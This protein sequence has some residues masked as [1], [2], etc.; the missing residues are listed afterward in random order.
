MFGQKKTSTVK[1]VEANFLTNQAWV[2]HRTHSG[3]SAF[4]RGLPY[5]GQFAPK[6]V[7]LVSVYRILQF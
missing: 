6:L 3:A 5:I 7:I 2:V 4:V 1:T